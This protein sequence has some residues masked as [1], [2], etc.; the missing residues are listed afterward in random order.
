MTILEV[1]NR[2]LINE[3]HKI[4]FSIYKN[5][6]NWIPHIKQDVEK[7]FNKEKNKYFRHGEAIRWILK[8][9]SGNCIGRIAAFVNHK[10]A[11]TEKQPTGGVGFFE[12]QKN[13]DG[14]KKMFDTAKK[15]LE[16]KGMEAMDGPINFGEKDKYWGLLVDGFD[17][18]PIY[19]NAYQPKYY[20]QFFE[21]YGFKTYFEQ[22]VY[23]RNVDQDI[24][25]KYKDR[26]ER[27][28]KNEAYTFRHLES[29]KMF[30]YA[31]DFRTVYN[32]AWTSHNNF[33]GMAASQ[34]RA[35]MRSMKPVMDEQLI[36]FAYHNNE[37]VAFF[38]ALPEL[39]EIFKHLNG[40]LNFL[41]KIK[42]LFY[43]WTKKCDNVFG[44]AF[45]VSPEHQRKGLEGALIM[46]IKKQFE[47]KSSNYKKL[48]ITWI[49]DFNPKMLHIID[50]LGAQKYMTLKTYRKLFDENAPFEKCK[51]I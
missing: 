26:S 6:K 43:K 1:N 49:G 9:E 23:S 16:S 33:K 4:P 32:K 30:E 2:K 34:A 21:D 40:N 37:P 51:T 27:I 50:N 20:Q 31:E 25:Q 18:A 8:D 17:K 44:L 38:I 36:W 7:V 15:W 19:G 42:F 48:I 29:K 39:N 11:K 41:G 22:Y 28:L 14:A 3:F 46:A 10:I 35:I 47:T 13:K 45:G 24:N 12:C 5:D